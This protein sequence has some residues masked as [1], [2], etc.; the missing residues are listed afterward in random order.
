MNV[1]SVNFAVVRREKRPAPLI[2][3]GFPGQVQTVE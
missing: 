3:K 1:H 2:Q